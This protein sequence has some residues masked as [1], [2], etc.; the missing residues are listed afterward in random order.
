MIYTPLASMEGGLDNWL[1]D[2]RCLVRRTYHNKIVYFSPLFDKKK[3]ILINQVLKDRAIPQHL[4]IVHACTNCMKINTCRG[5]IRSKILIAL[6]M[7]HIAV[8]SGVRAIILNPLFM[9]NTKLMTY[10][11]F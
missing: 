1:K 11:G 9:V 4:H 7:I 2:L 10:R 5:C 3:C 6:H 8:H